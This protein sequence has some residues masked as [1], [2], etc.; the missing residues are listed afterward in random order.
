MDMREGGVS[1]TG[2]P[3]RGK[4]FPDIRFPYRRNPDFKVCVELDRLLRPSPRM[5]A[6]PV[7]SSLAAASPPSQVRCQYGQ[8]GLCRKHVPSNGCHLTH[9]G[10]AQ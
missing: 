1:A 10:S 3:T 8:R 4:A 7:V 2:A 9:L 6:V 5:H